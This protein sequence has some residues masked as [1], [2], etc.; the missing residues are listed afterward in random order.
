[1]LNNVYVYMYELKYTRLH[2]VHKCGRF[3][4]IWFVYIQANNM[5]IPFIRLYSLAFYISDSFSPTRK[6]LS[7][8]K[9]L[10]S[11]ASDINKP[12]LIYKFMQLANHNALWNSK[13]V[14]ILDESCT[15]LSTVLAHY[16][17]LLW[18]LT[19]AHHAT[20]RSLFG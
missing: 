2:K 19:K 14:L 15:K 11:I 3:D 13:K 9:E 1:M 12:D 18:S 10:C 17:M 8:Y 4:F 20:W 5:Y 7:T 16:F 6:G